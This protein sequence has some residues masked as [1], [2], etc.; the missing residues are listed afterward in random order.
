MNKHKVSYLII[1]AIVIALVGF[2]VCVIKRDDLNSYP[3]NANDAGNAS[4]LPYG[5]APIWG[6][7][8]V[9]INDNPELSREDKISK[10]VAL[11]KANESNSDALQ[12]ILIS[13]TV[14]SPIEVADDLIPYLENPNPKVQIAALGVV[15][16]ASLLTQKEYELKRSLP[17]NEAIR[18]RIAN[19]VHELEINPNTTEEVR[20]ALTSIYTPS[21]LSLKDE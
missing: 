20:Q 7:S 1:A 14:L 9:G 16:N 12:A 11:L 15:Y 17:E 10:L 21:P 2:I 18:K 6:K 3:P 19:A 5:N 13:L 4:S 8:L